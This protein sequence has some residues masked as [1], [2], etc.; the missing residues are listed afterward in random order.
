MSE[1]LSELLTAYGDHL[2]GR[3]KSRISICAY[4]NPN[5]KL[6]QFLAGKGITKPGRITKDHLLDFQRFLYDERDF[7]H[8]TVATFLKHVAIFFDPFV[9]PGRLVYWTKLSI[10]VNRVHPSLTRVCNRQ[11]V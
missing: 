8:G 7:S 9:D 3:G 2:S 10:L 5:R 11:N 6:I 1:E 4:T